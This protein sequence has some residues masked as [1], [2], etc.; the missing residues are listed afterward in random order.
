GTF[1]H[2]DILVNNAGIFTQSL[3][4]ELSVADWD[5]VLNVNLRGTFLYALCAA[6]HARAGMGTHHQHRLTAR[7][8]R[9]PRGC[10]L[11]RQQGRGDSLYE[12]AG[13]GGG[14]QERARERHSPRSH[15][16]R[17]AGLGDRGT[18]SYDA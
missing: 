7:L 2:I 8:H 15:T 6:S 11:L 10:A 1:G 12:S 3:V 18:A 5:R 13:Q 17:S 9:R 4:E 16:H 14:D